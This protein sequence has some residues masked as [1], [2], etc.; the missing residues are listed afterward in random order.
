M[1]KAR[2]FALEK[3]WGQLYGKIPYLKHLD[4]VANCLGKFDFSNQVLI[5][6]A[7]LHDV[8]EDTDTTYDELAREFGLRVASTVY[9]LTNKG[10]RETIEIYYEKLMSNH[11]ALAIKIADR[12]CNIAACINEDT[13]DR[14][15]LERYLKGS[16]YFVEKFMLGSEK[17]YADLW[18]EYLMMIS[19]ATGYEER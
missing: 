1:D 10:G 18:E 3:H 6:C 15:R 4:R 5:T 9:A 14:K 8:L 12:L 11:T 13:E 16:D 7:Y 2:E 17:K 19:K